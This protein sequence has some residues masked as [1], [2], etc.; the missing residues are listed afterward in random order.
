MC[1]DEVERLPADAELTRE[2]EKSFDW[3]FS[4][5]DGKLANGVPARILEINDDGR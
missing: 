5:L 1:S 4:A 2:T 3:W